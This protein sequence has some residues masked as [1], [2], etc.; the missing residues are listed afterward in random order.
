[1]NQIAPARLGR[2]KP[3]YRRQPAIQTLFAGVPDAG[4]PFNYHII[5]YVIHGMDALQPYLVHYLYL[6]GQETINTRCRR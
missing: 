1:V 2:V 4:A 6:S 5:K 3:G